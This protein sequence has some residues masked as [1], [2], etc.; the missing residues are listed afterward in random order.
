VDV[1]AIQTGTVAVRSR[2]RVGVGSG[3]RRFL[4]TL[5]DREWTDPLP[6][7][8]W[9]ID[10]PEGTIVVDAGETSRVGERGYFPRW[11][12]YFR[13]GLREWVRP[14]EEIGRQLSARGI[15]VEDVRLVVLTHLHTDHAGGLHAFPG[16]DMIV[17][18]REMQLAAGLM[19]RM[20]G[21]LNNRFPDWFSPELVDFDDEPFG[22]FPASKRVTD[23][24]DVRL[25]PTPGHTP[26]HLSVIV[27]AEEC[28]YFLAGDSSYSEQLMLEGIVDGVAADDGEARLTL[29]RIRTLTAER[30]VVYL[31]SHDPASME[32][33]V[34]RRAVSDGTTATRVPAA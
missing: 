32:R 33:L 11:H 19:G 8:A 23:A 1:Y 22:P 6:I 18:R 9:V 14:E 20:R 34:A 29:E 10:H 26:G 27:E 21:Y 3:R 25:V 7:L 16:T 4:N 15:A 12:P 13:V 30:P 2:Q 28:L 5:T 17:S 24:G 31:P